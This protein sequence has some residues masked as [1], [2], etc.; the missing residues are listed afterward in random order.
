MHDNTK[1][2]LI[3]GS[4]SPRRRELLAH[5][6]LPFEVDVPDV[7][8]NS[9][10]LD[11]KAYVQEI[12]LKK[13][14][15]IAE[16]H[17]NLSGV[18]VCSDTTVSFEGQI[19]GKPQDLNEARAHLK[20]L[21]GHTHEV[22]TA[23]ALVRCLDGQQDFFCEV[24]RTQVDFINIPGPLLESYLDSGDSLDKAGSYGIQGGAQVFVKSITGSYSNVVG[25]PHHLFCEMMS[26]KLFPDSKDSAWLSFF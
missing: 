11:P 19:L 1:L 7:D 2:K 3:L 16:R 9:T 25:F 10:T 14:R 26:Q 13:A 4:A 12:A 22:F 21:S 15:A 23:I 6:K 8:E 20:L 5:Y 17:P 18:I 24:A